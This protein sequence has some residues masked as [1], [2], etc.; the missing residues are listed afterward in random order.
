[1]G[2][3][4]KMV[5]E[6]LFGRCCMRTLTALAIVTVFAVLFGLAERRKPL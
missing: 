6:T 5:V 2:E 3:W 1:M 4:G